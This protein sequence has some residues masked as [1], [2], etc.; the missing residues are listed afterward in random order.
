MPGPLIM[1]RIMILRGSITDT[2]VV[3]PE[4][5]FGK[6]LVK[7]RLIGYSLCHHSVFPLNEA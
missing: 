4:N 3:Y 7:N 1:A 2:G 6:R 5:S